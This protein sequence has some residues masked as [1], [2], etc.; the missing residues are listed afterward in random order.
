MQIEY[1]PKTVQVLTAGRVLLVVR[2]VGALDQVLV[3]L[4]VVF[5]WTIPG[6]TSIC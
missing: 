2:L 6:V 4:M 3:V 1:L 5:D